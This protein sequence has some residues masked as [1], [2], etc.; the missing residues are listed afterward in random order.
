[1]LYE[2][3]GEDSIQTAQPGPNPYSKGINS[4]SGTVL[5][6]RCAREGLNPYSNGRCSMKWWNL[7]NA[8]VFG[9]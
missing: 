9:S 1:M 8:R 5:V 7:F 6:F 2:T 3:C 4:M